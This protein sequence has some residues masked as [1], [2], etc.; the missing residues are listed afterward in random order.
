M[1]KIETER[2][3]LRR[4]A[5]HDLAAFIAYRN[6]PNI[7]RYQGWQALELAAAQNFI[8]A[9]QEIAVGTCD[10]WTQLAI[11]DKQS[12]ELLGDCALRV[13]DDGRQ[14]EVGITLA[15]QYHG[16]G[17][18]TEAL[19]GLFHYAFHE[20]KLH[21][22]V[23]IADVRN[24]SSITAMERLGMRREAL[25]VQAYWS[26]GEWTDEV[27]YAVLRDEWQKR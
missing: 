14:G 24:H 19:R 3:V 9:Q 11:A 4:L 10:E 7:G 5:A 16:R 2:L 21:R 17:Y 8:A 20:L 26:K 22:I 27:W 15:A 6:D 18:A 13:H 23:G 12:D 1:F 25:T